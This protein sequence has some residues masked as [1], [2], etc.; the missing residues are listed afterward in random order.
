MENQALI[1]SQRLVYFPI[2]YNP[3][4]TYLQRMNLPEN[5]QCEC[6]E[7]ETPLFHCHV[8]K[9]QTSEERKSLNGVTVTEMI[10]NALLICTCSEPK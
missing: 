7:I 6:R 5:D 10:N 1:T 2:G 9:E 4:P 3:Y 8:V